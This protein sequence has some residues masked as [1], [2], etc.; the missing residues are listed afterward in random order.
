MFTAPCLLRVKSIKETFLTSLQNRTSTQEP[1]FLCD[2]TRAKFAFR[3]RKTNFSYSL[4]PFK[5]Y[6]SWR[7][8][9][10]LCER[11]PGFPQK[12]YRTWPDTL[13]FS[14]SVWRTWKSGDIFP[15]LRLGAHTLRCHEALQLSP[16]TTLEGC[17][18]KS[19]AARAPASPHVQLAPP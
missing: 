18:G 2:L 15:E 17:W 10:T 5:T 7:K 6:R 8:I 1:R 3:D 19:Q 14:P 13:A 12:G 4:S 9:T 16:Q 11:Q